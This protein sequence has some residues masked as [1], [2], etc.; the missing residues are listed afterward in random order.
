MARNKSTNGKKTDFT[1]LERTNERKLCAE[2]NN[3]T[4]LR[5]LREKLF[6][7]RSD[8][9][10]LTYGGFSNL[11]ESPV[12]EQSLL[13]IETSRRKDARELNR[14]NN[15]WQSR[16]GFYIRRRRDRRVCSLQYKWR[17]FEWIEISERK[18]RGNEFRNR[19][20]SFLAEYPKGSD[21]LCLLQASTETLRTSPEPYDR[22][23]FRRNRIRRRGDGR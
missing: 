19:M 12:L 2:R 15:P 22:R 18:W 7:R 5:V 20:K 1:L 11:V 13:V 10:R 17:E 21:H 23:Y 4:N 16:N 3:A 8:I 9:T 14:R 6:I